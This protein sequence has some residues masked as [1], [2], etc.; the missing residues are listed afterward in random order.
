MPVNETNFEFI[1]VKV[2]P[3]LRREV[4]RMAKEEDRSM[5]S[6]CRRA[7]LEYVWRKVKCKT[8]K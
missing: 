2:P 7:V 5:S 1:M 6:L 8:P 3:T 4:E